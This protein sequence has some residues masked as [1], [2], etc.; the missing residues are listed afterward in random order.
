MTTEFSGKFLFTKLE[1]PTKE[2]SP[3]S[4][5]VSIIEFGAIQHLSPIIALPQII[6]PT[7]I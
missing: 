6:L 7:V 3:N 1:T 5:P 4:H 2:S